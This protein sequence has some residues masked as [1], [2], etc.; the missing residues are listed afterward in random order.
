MTVIRSLSSAIEPLW[1]RLSLCISKIE[2][3]SSSL[4]SISVSSC[5]NEVLSPLLPST[6]KILA[7]IEAFFVTCGKLQ[8]GQMTPAQLKY[9]SAPANEVKEATSLSESSFLSKSWSAPQR[10]VDEK[11]KQHNE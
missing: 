4:P 8:P 5:A 6:Q 10:K 9:A 1:K 2:N 3:L 11:G 7:Y